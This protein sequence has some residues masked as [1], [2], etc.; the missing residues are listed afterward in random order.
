MKQPDPDRDICECGDYR[1]QH[2]EGWRDCVVCQP[3][4]AMNGRECLQF[5]PFMEARVSWTTT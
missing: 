1:R 4:D 3:N 2:T 5:R